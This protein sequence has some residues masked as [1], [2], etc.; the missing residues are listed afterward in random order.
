LIERAGVGDRCRLEGGDFF[1]AVPAGGDAYI[2]KNIIHDWDDDRSVT[3]LTNIRK[4][5]AGKPEGRV[6]LLD[7]V[8]P[9]DNAP[10][11][12]KLID[13][14]MM[15]MPGGKERTADEF[16]ALFARAGFR[17]TAIVPTASM[18]SVVEARV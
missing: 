11:L 3:I 14:E 7:A 6:I 8:V 1:A 16:S 2:M 10:H 18:L 17:L 5:L 12:S 4:A 15:V 13:L 9:A